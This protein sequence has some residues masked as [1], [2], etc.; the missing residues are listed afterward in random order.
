ML[1]IAADELKEREA[2]LIFYKF[3]YNRKINH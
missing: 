1:I 2:I 3:L